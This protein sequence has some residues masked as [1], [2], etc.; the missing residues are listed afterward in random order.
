MVDSIKRRFLSLIFYYPPFYTTY[1]LAEIY[2]CYY[3][4]GLRD[5]PVYPNKFTIWSLFEISA[6]IT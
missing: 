5:G 3:E 6:D 1:L 2:S 4:L